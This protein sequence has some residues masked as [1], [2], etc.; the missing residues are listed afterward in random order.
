MKMHDQVAVERNADTLGFGIWLPVYG[1]WLRSVSHPQAPNVPEALALAQQAE[2]LNFDFLYASENLL[3]C[4]HGPSTNVIDA[5]SLI[6]ALGVTTSRID[7]CGAIKPGFRSPLLVARM[8]DTISQIANR[9]LS[10]NIVCGWWQDEFRLGDVDWLDHAKRYDRA[11]EFLR[12]LSCLFD[13]EIDRSYFNELL[14]DVAFRPADETLSSSHSFGLE[15][16]N[17]PS[18]WVAGHSNRAIE[19]TACWGDC[20]FI[21]GMGDEELTEQIVRMRQAAAKWGRKVDIALNAY[22]IAAESETEAL[23]QRDWLIQNRNLATI[24]YF[25]KIMAESEASTWENLDDE[26]MVDSN[27]GFN[28]GLIGSFDQVRAKVEQLSEAGVNKIVCQFDNPLRDAA[29][30]MEK[31]IKPFRSESRTTHLLAS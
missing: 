14:E 2:A 30:F 6:A 10:M 1:G 25:R 20:L 5:W 18:V 28:A 27:A 12:T 29:P 17:R 16:K 26:Q 22:V 19:M 31:V 11:D 23:R 21:N 3:N 13:P 8:I 9:R 4:I 15:K 7:I 24:D